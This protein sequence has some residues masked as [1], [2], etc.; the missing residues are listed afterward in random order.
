MTNKFIPTTILILLLVGTQGVVAEECVFDTENQVQV[1]QELQKHY[2][3]SKLSIQDRSIEMAWGKGTIKYQRGGC[4]HFGETIVYT[5]TER[6][7]YSK[8]ELLFAQA[9]KMGDDFFRDMMSGREL[10]E[11]LAMKLYQHRIM[12]DGDWYG[13]PHEYLIDLSIM[14]S[15]SE[16]KQTIEIGYYIN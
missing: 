7:D 10:A 2:P 1:L 15:R 11:L 8:R 3:D 9:I 6:A 13:I 14:Y 4:D 12:E 16:K 5:T